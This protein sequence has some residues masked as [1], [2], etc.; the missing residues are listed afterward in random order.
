METLQD[1]YCC[2][3]K[4]SVV[5]RLTSGVELYPFRPD[6]SAL[7]FWICDTCQSYVGCHNKT[8]TPTKPLGVL[9]TSEIIQKRKAIH[10]IID[11]LWKTGKMKR[12]QVYGEMSRR[13]GYAFHSA[14][15]RSVG[16]AMHAIHVGEDIAREAHAIN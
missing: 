7:P 2:G 13:L 11:P 12:K 10:R 6:L 9:A 16:Q 3:C 5:A 14:E 8:K 1:I 15:I 4:R